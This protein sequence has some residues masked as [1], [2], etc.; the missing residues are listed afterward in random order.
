[1]YVEW[2]ISDIVSKLANYK[3]CIMKNEKIDNTTTIEMVS[4]VKA[5]GELQR[6]VALRQT[7][8]SLLKML[9]IERENRMVIEYADHNSY[10]WDGTNKHMDIRLIISNTPILE[11]KRGAPLFSVKIVITNKNPQK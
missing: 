8:N 11:I 5:K 9:G 3:L 7:T 1:M 4:T 6:A 2:F 10:R